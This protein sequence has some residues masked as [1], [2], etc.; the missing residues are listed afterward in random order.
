MIEP[1]AKLK[2]IHA[3]RLKVGDI[4][5]MIGH[6]WTVNQIEVLG[7]IQDESRTLTRLRFSFKEKGDHD[8]TMEYL[9]RSDSLV[10]VPA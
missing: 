5:A 1:D 7:P 2:Q 8:R 9:F 3:S 10:L 6:Y 4:V